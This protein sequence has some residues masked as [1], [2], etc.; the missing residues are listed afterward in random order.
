MRRWFGV[1]FCL[2]M[3]GGP[4]GAQVVGPSTGGAAAV[5]Q[6]ERMQ[7]HTK[8]VLMIAAHP[9][10]EDTEL[11]TYLVRREGAVAAY[12]SL[13]RGEGGQNLIGTE[14]GEA[15]GLLRS[16]ELLA[17]R[18]LDGARQ[19]FTRSFDFGFS[20][21]LDETLMF[22]PRD[23]VLKDVVRVIRRFRP[24]IV[25]S[26][27]S[28]TPR[29]GHGQHQV[30]GWA[31]Q[32][33][34]AAAGDPNRFPELAR[35]DGLA[36]WTPQ[37]LYR[38]ARFDT[39]GTS[40][41]LQGGI[42]DPE[43]GQSY[44]QIAMR[45]RSLHRSQDM[46]MLQE[47]GPSPIRIA[48]LKDK[49]GGGAPLFAG[50]DTTAP[51]AGSLEAAELEGYRAAA[52]AARA[53]LVVDAIADNGRVVG[54]QKLR[55]RLSVWN[56]GAQVATARLAVD[57]PPGWKAGG[58]CLG[59]DVSIQS[60]A[61]SHCAVD[62]EVGADAPVTV[63]YF[64]REPRQGALYRW[65]GDRSIWGDPFDPPL[66]TARFQVSASGQPSVTVR[67]E[68]FYRFRDQAL[69]EI[70]RPIAVVPRVGVS[71]T[72]S[73]KVW[74]VSTTGPQAVA[75]A[76]EHAGP[77]S[78]WGTVHLDLP[79]G[80]PDVPP[81]PFRLVRPD[82]HRAF[83]FS[84][85]PPASLAPG[86]YSVRASVRDGSGARYEA[87]LVTV[88]YPHIRERSFARPSTMDVHAA[89]IVL[90]H[91]RRIGYVR[92]AADQVPE[93]LSGVGLS[94]DVLDAAALERSDLGRFDVIV[95]GSRA[96]ETD[97]ALIENNGR[98]LDYV[99]EGG[100]VLVQYQQFPFFNGNFAPYPLTVAPQHDRVIDENA[101]VRILAPNDP[102]FRVPNA[103]ESRDWDGWVQER[104]L[105]FAHTWDS[106]YAPL[107]EL[108]DAGG[109]RLEGG[110]LVTQHGRGTYIYTGL[111]F[112]RQ[113]PAGV[114]GAF[115]L[116]FNL[117]DTSSRAPVP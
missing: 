86:R 58:Q 2:A 47:M 84:V 14:L 7:G 69:G 66:V 111:A 15:L 42:L 61:V 91:A 70:R 52:V 50:V 89:A 62:L 92:G 19:F 90:P 94:V 32:E 25:V 65:V 60:G 18:S 114:P 53:G 77:D 112:F 26:I 8:R 103:I 99:R 88:S 3:L 30:A 107:L 57:A 106:K 76:L 40:V 29:D 95:I 24:Q 10:D 109:P 59:T 5:V 37:K 108:H 13:T 68:V 44:R 48:L 104:G 100:H 78:T 33:A 80:W 79:A 45:G 34:F 41:V 93:A 36:P 71:V 17:A 35:D 81:Q 116:F 49:T 64:L 16:E 39:S 115:R 20:K 105:Y 63:P 56:T 54:G 74:P 98:V 110:L 96:Y 85:K 21:T 97:P 73:I 38:S 1:T 46:G 113:L 101:P 72:P 27:F 23:S 67:R 6:A 31:A 83:T 55:L 102:A 28:G 12:L 11:L 82:E 43:I 87:G 4:L 75:V 22:W 9:D 51:K 117:L